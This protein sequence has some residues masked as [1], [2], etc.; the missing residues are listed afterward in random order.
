M[1]NWVG[2]ERETNELYDMVGHSLPGGG[3]VLVLGVGGSGKTVLAR[4]IA[5]RFAQNAKR[6]ATWIDAR[7]PEAASIF[8]SELTR[9]PL[10]HLV[11]VDGLD[12]A[13]DYGRPLTHV[14]NDGLRQKEYLHVLATAPV[15]P[16]LHS[17]SRYALGPMFDS[18]LQDLVKNLTGLK[19]VPPP[20]LLH[21]I[22]GH[23]LAASLVAALV[24]ERKVDYSSVLGLLRDF[25]RPGLLDATGRPI[26]SRNIEHQPLI[27]DVRDANS[28]LLQRLRARPEFVYQLSPR[29]FEEI[30]AEIFARLGYSVELTPRSKD[31]GVDILLAQ[32]TDV[33]SFL[34]FVEC[35]LYAA[36]RPVGIELVNALVGVV[37][38]GKATAGLLM[39]TSR[40]T[41]GAKA[42]E[43][44]LSA[45]LSLKDYGDFKAYLE[46]AVPIRS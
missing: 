19:E 31:G 11:I 41:S 17:F 22:D 39:T 23:P 13:P 46:K 6:P 10:G 38:R 34:Y 44:E 35:K 32:K 24:R 33:G 15:D 1:E 45:R 29:Q 42:V 30:S 5:E 27:A 37:E 4:K 20:E 25:Q 21:F 40:F 2:R 26:S 36:D 12:E 28:H 9:A 43:K 3:G 14:I 18:D 8:S 7:S 16:G